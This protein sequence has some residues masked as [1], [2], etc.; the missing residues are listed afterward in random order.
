M[1]GKRKIQVNSVVV[2]VAICGKRQVTLTVLIL[3]RVR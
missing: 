2:V 3:H 1:Y